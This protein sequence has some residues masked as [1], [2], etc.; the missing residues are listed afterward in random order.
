MSSIYLILYYSASL[1][2]L[3]L[4]RIHRLLL[5]LFINCYCCYYYCYSYYCYSLSLML[6]VLTNLLCH[7]WRCDTARRLFRHNHPP[8]PR[9][10][11]V[12]RIGSDIW[13]IFHVWKCRHAPSVELALFNSAVISRQV[14]IFNFWIDC[15]C[16][17]L[18]VIYF[19]GSSFYL[20]V[21]L[22]AWI[23]IVLL[24]FLVYLS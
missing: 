24:I 6:L 22:F 7:R 3:L 5:L 4:L 8:L 2:H 19:Y 13:T 16:H 14:S 20:I 15:D 10:R 23:V 17:R 21:T 12:Q 9:S 11:E 18:H 1:I